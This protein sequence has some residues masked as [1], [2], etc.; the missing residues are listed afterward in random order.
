MA[1]KTIRLDPRAETLLA[2]VVRRTGMTPSQALRAGLATLHE[3]LRA[4]DD[5]YAVYERLDLGPGAD[6]EGT[7]AALLELPGFGPW[8]VAYLA[9]RALRDPDAIPIT[10][11]GIRKALDRFGAGGTPSDRLARTERW[12]PWRAYAAMHLWASLSNHK[13]EARS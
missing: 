7:A 13:E 6:R 9:M 4:R 11:L 1:V 3:R 10:D 5:P 2:D 12:R 8:T